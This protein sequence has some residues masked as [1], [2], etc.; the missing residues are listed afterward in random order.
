MYGVI[1]GQS[2]SNILVFGAVYACFCLLF[3]IYYIETED[4]RFKKQ[5]QTSNFYQV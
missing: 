5:K 1:I 3:E 4:V 2:Q